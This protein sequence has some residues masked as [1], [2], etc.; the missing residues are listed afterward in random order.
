MEKSLAK[1][2]FFFKKHSMFNPRTKTPETYKK[3][4]TV[5]IHF[6]D[7]YKKIAIYRSYNAFNNPKQI[8]GNR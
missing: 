6:T 2:N 3:T 1:D 5:H 8:L 7:S 4:N